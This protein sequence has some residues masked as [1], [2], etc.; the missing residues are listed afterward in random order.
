M[1]PHGQGYVSVVMVEQVNG[2]LEEFRDHC[3]RFRIPKEE[4]EEEQ[5]VIGWR[6]CNIIIP[7]RARVD[8]ETKVNDGWEGV[9]VQIPV[10]VS[11]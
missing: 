10:P 8:E 7:K 1:T 6:C 5:E 2:Y 9:L 11:E 3:E 4:E